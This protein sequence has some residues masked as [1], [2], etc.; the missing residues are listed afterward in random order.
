M[1][2]FEKIHIAAPERISYVT[3]EVQNRQVLADK[4]THPD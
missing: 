1:L 3:L 2:S 4:I